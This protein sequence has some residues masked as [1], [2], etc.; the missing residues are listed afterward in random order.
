[1]SLLDQLH[2]PLLRGCWVRWGLHR[3]HYADRTRKLDL[4]YRV[5]NPWRM[6]SAREQA[7]FAWTNEVIA[8]HLPQPE[9]LLE[10]GCGEGHQSQYLAR[11]CRRL[12]GIDISSRA[13][14]RA[15]RRCPQGNFATGEPAS[16]RFADMPPVVDLVT[17]CEVVYYVKDTAR[18]VERM[19]ALGRNCLVTYYE[20]HAG[21]L[22]RHFV[23]LPG[24]E[25]ESFRFG[26]VVW[27][28]VWWR[29]GEN[30]PAADAEECVEMTN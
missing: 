5:E 17:A 16:F 1:M 2:A 13:V 23:N 4:L 3:V 25:R 6:D 19:S 18:F 15:R 21:M 12:Y 7:R 27:V 26:E 24:C 9:T 28:A 20:G 29:N 11:V 30:A 14:Q 10:I 8:K 22:D